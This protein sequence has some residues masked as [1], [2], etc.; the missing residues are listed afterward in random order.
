MP[1]IK[2]KKL[3]TRSNAGEDTGKT[4]LL[5]ECLQKIKSYNQ[6]GK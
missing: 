1:T 6:S 4:G 2:V 3:V 5:R